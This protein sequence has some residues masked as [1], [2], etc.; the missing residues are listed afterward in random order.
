MDKKGSLD[1]KT[2]LTGFILFGVFAAV[3]FGAFGHT[4]GKYGVSDF[5]ESSTYANIEKSNQLAQDL[6]NVIQTNENSQDSPWDTMVKGGYLVMKITLNSLSQPIAIFQDFLTDIHVIDPGFEINPI[7]V[8]AIVSII[9]VSLVLVV[10]G[11]IFKA[12]I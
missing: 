8:V 12:N 3:F 7:F 6:V 9:I 1:F 4:A 2:Y 10:I 5:N 11:A